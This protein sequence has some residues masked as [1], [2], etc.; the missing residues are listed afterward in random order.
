MKHLFTLS[1]AALLLIVTGCDTADT[2]GPESVD[3]T[4]GLVK[5]DPGS[6]DS[7]GTDGQV[8]LVAGQNILVGVVNVSDDGTTLF[9]EYD[10]NGWCVTEVHVAVTHP[11]EKPDKRSS[12][13][14]T[15]GDTDR[16]LRRNR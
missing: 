6:F 2:F 10:L 5:Y 1:V 9:V 4:T 11:C 3:S 14:G 8:D 13:D 16:F 12:A 7:D 15:E